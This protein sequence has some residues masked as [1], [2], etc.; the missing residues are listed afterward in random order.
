MSDWVRDGVLFTAAIVGAVSLWTIAYNVE[1][2]RKLL[3]QIA[4]SSD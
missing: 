4:K 2:I 1:K 3:E